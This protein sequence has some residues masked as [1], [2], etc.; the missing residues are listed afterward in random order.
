MG[1]SGSG[2]WEK[3]AGKHKWRVRSLILI[4]DGSV[5]TTDGEVDL[6][7]R[8]YSGKLLEWT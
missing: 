5:V 7:S 4:S 6:A 2:V 1:G 3:L 8:G